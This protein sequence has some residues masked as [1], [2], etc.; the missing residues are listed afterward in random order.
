M[1][2]VDIVV[3]SHGIWRSLLDYPPDGV[4]YSVV[5]P[6]RARFP[7]RRLTHFGNGLLKTMRRRGIVDFESVKVFYALPCKG[8][9]K[10]HVEENMTYVALSNFAKLTF[11]AN[12][13]NRCDVRVIRPG[14]RVNRQPRVQGDRFDIL[15]VS[16]ATDDGSFFGKGGLYLMDALKRLHDNSIRLHTASAIN[17]SDESLKGNAPHY[18]DSEGRNWT[19]LYRE[20]K[21]AGWLID[22]GRM[23]RQSVLKLMSSAR[24]VA[25]PA[26]Y[27]TVC[28]SLME[29]SYL[30]TPILTSD[31][32]FMKEF[33]GD[34]ATFVKAP[35]SYYMPDGSF[36]CNFDEQI[37]AVDGDLSS[38]WA[39]TIHE[40]VD[41]LSSPSNFKVA[42]E[43]S[44]AKFER[45]I[46][47]RNAAL[48]KLY[49]EKEAN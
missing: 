29:A 11:E 40:T 24:L 13:A 23:E 38:R 19:A 25:I 33:Y 7:S 37:R 26:F 39:D 20:A 6:L 14:V 16:G 35:A 3:P 31:T 43:L 5:S 36:N 41:R 10:R 34:I 46:E 30:G 21:S 28:Y 8:M 49:E 42:S 44:M 45:S 27:D 12:I 15:F 4:S 1:L 48:K 2:Q 9:K 22:H 17:A 47:E 18:L 32:M